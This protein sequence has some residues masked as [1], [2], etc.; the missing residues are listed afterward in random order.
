MADDKP[1]TGFSDLPKWPKDATDIPEPYRPSGGQGYPF[2][3][4]A[5]GAGIGLVGAV[6]RMTGGA[7]AAGAITGVIV[8]GVIGY[9]L[10]LLASRRQK[11]PD[12]R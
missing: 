1:D 4:L 12:D 10:G 3:G 9:L 2:V 7:E 5:I 8:L 6:P 11:T